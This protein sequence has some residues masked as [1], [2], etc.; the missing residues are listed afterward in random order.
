MAQ[1]G[2]QPMT[3]WTMF[4]WRRL[5]SGNGKSGMEDSK[6]ELPAD[7]R[8][9]VYNVYVYFCRRP[10]RSAKVALS[11]TA[12][13]TMLPRDIVADIIRDKYRE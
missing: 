10:G 7:T 12:S 6:V 9:L 13:A 1:Y 11:K 4:S 5:Y 3:A 2:D 8:Q